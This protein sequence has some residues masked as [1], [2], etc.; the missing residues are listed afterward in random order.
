MQK[1]KTI[2]LISIILLIL[3]F[4]FIFVAAV[5]GQTDNV[6]DPRKSLE[7]ISAEEKAVL[8]ELFFLS[9]EIDEMSRRAEELLLESESV[10][11]KITVMETDIL[12]RQENYDIQLEILE[13]VMVSY[14]K[15]GM[16]SSLETLLSAKNLTDFLKRLN[17][18]QELSRNTGEM[19]NTMKE[20]KNKLI[21]EREMLIS[22]KALL[23][24]KRA[25]LQKAL[26]QKMQLKQEQEAFLES[27]SE[28]KEHYQDQLNKLD[29][30][31]SEV[32]VLFSNISTEFSRVFNESDLYIDDFNLKFDFL[33]V[34]GSITDD[35]MNEIIEKDQKLPK[36]VFDIS[37]ERIQIEVPEKYLLLRGNITIESESVIKF[38][39]TEGTFY[40]MQLEKASIDELFRD[41]YL[42]ID[43]SEL[44]GDIALQSVQMKEGFIE[45]KVKPFF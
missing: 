22:N 10:A 3:C 38:E 17:V 43:F 34:I 32:K 28:E 7:Y 36:M 30:S 11:Q 19:L 9:Q 41:G 26:D 16:A 37:P 35:K 13:K 31:W 44:I 6:S 42:L 21:N 2:P 45:F 18:I 20:E 25:E 14:Q 40:G 29:Q 24:N 4:A 27:L 8:E 12:E 33:S 39:V 5:Y 23:E 1:T 15:N